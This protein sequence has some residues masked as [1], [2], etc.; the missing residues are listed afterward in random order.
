MD[1]ICLSCGRSL[2]HS[3]TSYDCGDCGRSYPVRDGIASFSN[4]TY[5][6]NIIPREP[7]LEFLASLST[8]AWDEAFYELQAKLPT[9]ARGIFT[10]VLAFRRAGWKFLLPRG[11]SVRALDLGCGWG[12]ISIALAR[13]C[14]EVV[15]VD[16]TVERL[17]SLKEFAAF[18][19]LDNLRF[20]HAGDG[21]LPFP[22]ASFDV[23]VLNGVLEWVPDGTDGDP[24]EVQRRYLTEV[25]RILKPNGTLYIAI[26]NRIAFRYVLRREDHVGLYWSSFL[27]R[28]V[29]NV[30]SRW[31]RGRDY[32][33][34]TYGKSG[35]RKLLKASGFP[36]ARFFCPLPD[37]RYPRRMSYL[38]RPDDYPCD[39]K[40]MSRWK[41]PFVYSFSIVAKKS[42]A[43]ADGFQ[44]LIN[45]LRARL[46]KTSLRCSQYLVRKSE[47]IL[48]LRDSEGQQ[49]VTRLPYGERE[50]G[51]SRSNAGALRFL[52]EHGGVPGIT[53]P[54]L[55]FEDS[56]GRDHVTVETMVPGS[57]LRRILQ[58]QNPSGV[59]LALTDFLAAFG[60]GH[61]STTPGAA[62]A[63]TA[64]S[65]LGETVARHLVDRNLRSELT[66]LCRELVTRLER[67]EFLA[68]WAHGDF[69]LGNCLWS[70]QTKSLQS[71]VDWDQMQQDGMPGWDFVKLI[72]SVRR[73]Q[74]RMSIA[75]PLAD[76]V[77]T[78]F[79]AEERLLWER[80]WAVLGAQKVELPLVAATQWIKVTA[81]GFL[82]GY[83]HLN[84]AWIERSIRPALSALTHRF[85]TA[86]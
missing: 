54:S 10:N 56:I 51:R 49:Y 52:E 59:L 67:E 81:Y 44:E 3:S 29:S 77:L 72:G 30:Y 40:E 13:S 17:R 84:R 18:E 37:Y 38:E 76:I 85:A 65:S 78:D 64:V 12:C 34:Y 48:F 69:N 74:G 68:V 41:R 15:S 4:S 23:V 42:N 26:E 33:T 71:L 61:V 31:A 80:Y 25:A 39:D 28:R 7:M 86:T 35:Y 63:I 2:E 43:G 55:L 45:T 14:G 24:R 70:T 8:R 53:I 5:Y 20:I 1:L 46:G 36:D 11:E 83:R 9:K 58:H 21:P 47:T 79:T 75:D 82:H 22:D 73:H 6:Y 19:K 50:A 62:N 32:R 57:D 60:R 66:A 16:L 27:P